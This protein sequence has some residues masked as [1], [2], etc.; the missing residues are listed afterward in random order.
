MLPITVCLKPSLHRVIQMNEPD[1]KV[2]QTD[3]S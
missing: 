3:Y 2:N 1:E